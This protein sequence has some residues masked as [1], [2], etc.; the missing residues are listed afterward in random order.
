MA[1]RDISPKLKYRYNTTQRSFSSRK[2]EKY[3]RYV[4]SSQLVS[5]PSTIP[6]V[7]KIEKQ[8]F[9]LNVN[10]YKHLSG[11]HSSLELSTVYSTVHIPCLCSKP[12]DPKMLC[13]SF[14]PQSI[15]FMS[16]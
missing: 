15:V 6:K 13:F 8:V 7:L 3:T 4:I 9:L 12:G 14:R 1:F 16:Q 2:H 10:P 5:L 11:D